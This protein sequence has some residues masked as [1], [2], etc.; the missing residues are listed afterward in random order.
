M[1]G[2]AAGRVA[3]VVGGAGAIGR[4]IAARLFSQQANVHVLDLAPAAEWRSSPSSLRFHAVD[5]SDEPGVDGVIDA[6]ARA[7]GRLDYLVYCAGIF[8]PRGLMQMSIEDLTRTI[9]TNLTG[10]FLCCRG[11]L[12]AMRASGFGRIVLISSMLARTGAAN[13]ADYAAS[14]GGLIGLA[15]SLALEAAGEGIRVNTVSPGVV[16]TAMPR[17]HSSDEALAAVGRSIPLGRIAHVDDVAEACLFLLG[18]DSSY[19]TGQDLRVNGGATL[20]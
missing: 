2:T 19:L 3:L 13:G 7:E 14:K 18:D 16:D 9:T 4:A 1:P 17:A 8:R 15:R 20:W 10:A 6:I 11:A 12:R 5:V